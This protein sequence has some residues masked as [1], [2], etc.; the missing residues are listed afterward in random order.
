MAVPCLQNWTL[1]VTTLILKNLLP[2]ILVT[3]FSSGR[4]CVTIIACWVFSAK[5]PFMHPALV[6][7]RRWRSCT[8]C[9]E[10][11]MPD[12]SFKVVALLY[13][14]ICLWGAVPL[15]VGFASV[16]T[17]SVLF[18]KTVGY[19]RRTVNNSIRSAGYWWFV[20]WRDGLPGR[21]Q[22]QGRFH[23]WLPI[24]RA[25]SAYINASNNTYCFL[26]QRPFL[27]QAPVHQ[28]LQLGRR[29]HFPLSSSFFGIS[30]LN[31]R[32]S[33]CL[34]M[35][36]GRDIHHK[37]SEVRLF[38]DHGYT[39]TSLMLKPCS[40]INGGGRKDYDNTTGLRSPEKWAWR[41]VS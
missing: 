18:V 8:L 35:R 28:N 26:I 4:R 40:D 31:F 10:S 20:I 6:G 1:K 37:H 12:V 14:I 39:W 25:A 5:V 34:T 22:H 9:E 36:P 16:E 29:L 15:H 7:R 11:Q 27:S 17:R 38:Q 24:H 33:D 23:Y 21:T 41:F 19:F 30:S 13:A 3:L 2:G 32:V